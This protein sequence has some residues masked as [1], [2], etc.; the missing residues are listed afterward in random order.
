MV[1]PYQVV[2]AKAIGADCILLIAS[3]LDDNQMKELDDCARGL[4]MD[5][6]VEVHDAE[7]FQR[8]L[9]LPAPLL[10]INNRNLHTFE[11]T[12]ETTFG[13]LDQVP[14]G[15]LLVTESGIMNTRDV[16]SM[17]DKNVNAFLVGETFMRAED[18]GAQ[19]AG[20]FFS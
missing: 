12:L 14:A 10:G 9:A 8:A 5:V 20:M 17:R 6:L 2:E 15:T 18:P 3:C 13:L 1:D 7:E 19:L 4:G 11:L 16:L